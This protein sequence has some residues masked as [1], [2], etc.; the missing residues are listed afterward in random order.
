MVIWVALFSASRN[1]EQGATNMHG[2]K[3]VH[4]LAL[5]GFLLLG[6]GCSSTEGELL[7]AINN[8][9]QT[10]NLCVSPQKLGVDYFQANDG[11]RY[12]AKA[13][14]FSFSQEYGGFDSL[15]ALQ[16][17]GYASAEATSLASSWANYKNAYLATD[18]I[19]GYLG[20]FDT[21]CIGAMRATEIIEYTEPGDAG[22]QVMQARFK[23]KIEFNDLVDD[24][25]IEG[26]LTKGPIAKIWPGTGTSMYTKTNKGWRLQMATWSEF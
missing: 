26:H 21:I 19:N 4:G 10:T 13:G 23:Y 9:Q 17:S 8:D 22:P 16:K 3:T 5:V 25:D 6:S 20:Q 18:K 11:K 14:D 15:P 24:L 2:L 1:V 12:F 7:D